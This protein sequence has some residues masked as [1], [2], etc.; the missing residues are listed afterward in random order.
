MKLTPR[1]KPC[2]YHC[3]VILDWHKFVGPK[4][5]G[6]CNAEQAGDAKREKDEL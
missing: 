1:L 6:Q 2:L 4:S 5:N 3:I